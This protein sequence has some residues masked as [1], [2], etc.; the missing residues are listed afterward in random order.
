M[1][2][3]PQLALV[4]VSDQLARIEATLAALMQTVNPPKVWLSVAEAAAVKHV[5]QATIRRK[6]AAGQ[7]E[8]RGTGKT[9]EVKL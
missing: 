6:I 1:S 9:R 2:A 3:R 4:D 8:V 5:S 7:Y